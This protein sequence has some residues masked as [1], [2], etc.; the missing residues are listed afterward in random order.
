MACRTFGERLDDLLEGRLSPAD[1]RAADEHLRSCA[2]CRELKSLV[3]EASVP[4]TP[5]ADLLGA[6]LARTSGSACGSARVRLCDHI[7]RLLAPADDDLVRMHLD[8][9]GECAGLAARLARLAADLPGGALALE[10]SALSHVQPGA[11]LLRGV[12]RAEK[13]TWNRV[14]PVCV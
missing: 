3:A 12:G 5:P 7:D 8:A 1:R 13:G 10:R 6:V 4:V 2:G 14:G 11:T 9:C